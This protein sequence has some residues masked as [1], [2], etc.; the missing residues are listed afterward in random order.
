MVLIMKKINIFNLKE[1]E[2][3]ELEK[4][5][6]KLDCNNIGKNFINL[7]KVSLIYKDERQG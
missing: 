7:E 3:N 5:I 4:E 2:K 1:V 6:N